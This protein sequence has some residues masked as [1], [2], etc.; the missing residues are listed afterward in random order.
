MV[1]L[2]FVRKGGDS[3]HLSISASRLALVK[4]GEVDSC[5]SRVYS[6]SSGDVDLFQAQELSVPHASFP[7][8]GRHWNTTFFTS[9][10]R[11]AF[12]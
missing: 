10:S 5:S 2:P 12:N 3:C 7:D 11:S 8:C 6:I 4:K 1:C 9:S